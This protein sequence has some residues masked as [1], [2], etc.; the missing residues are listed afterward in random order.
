M[1][2]SY[3]LTNHSSGLP[4]AAAELR[5]QA[6]GEIVPAYPFVAKSTANLEPGQHWSI[7]LTGGRFGCGIVL[8]LRFDDDKL[9][10]RSVGEQAVLRGCNNRV[11]TLLRHGGLRHFGK[12][13]AD[14]EF[15]LA[16]FRIHK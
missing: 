9:L 5:R 8:A 14:R 2:V 3:G 16:A 13:A 12:F 6:A 11:S 10:H 7:P 15:T 4:P 1:H